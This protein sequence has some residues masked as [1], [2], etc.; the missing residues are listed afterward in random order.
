MQLKNLGNFSIAINDFIKT[1]N[2]ASNTGDILS[3]S[4]Q[5]LTAAEILA[6]AATLN[7]TDSQKLQLI[8]EYATD[9][10]NYTTVESLAALSASEATATTT[11][12]GLSTAFKGLAASIG[13]AKLIL[14]GITVALVAGLAIWNMHQN[15]LENIR[16]STEESANAYKETTSSID[17]YTK[18]YQEL[19]QALIDAKGNEEETYNI[20]KQLLDLQTELND[21][22]G[23]EY[24]KLNLVTDAYKD[25]SEAIKTFNKEAAQTFL[26][27]NQEGI[28]DAT[29]AMTKDN[30]RYNLSGVGMSPYTDEGMALKEIAKKYEN[31]GLKI[32][33][34]ESN[35]TYNLILT[36]DAQSAY[37]TINE[38]ENDVRAKAK[39]LGDEH[40]FDD[41]LEISSS[42]L[43]RAK[44]IINDYGNIYK[45]ALMAEIVTDDDRSSTYN[46]ALKAV[47]EYNE[48]V[49]KS[50]NPFN[51]EEVA[52]TKA[53]I[54]CEIHRVNKQQGQ[55]AG[56]A[57]NDCIM[58]MYHYSPIMVT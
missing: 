32:N 19:R 23:E 13:T 18:R 21:K 2:L 50:E 54:E 57:Y 31:Q 17:D 11:T 46:E 26:N 20:K 3:K 41:V 51:D 24:G 5:K 44:E 7:L 43:N 52:R 4:F 12:G 10:A 38:F 6:K 29:K 9:A 8:T 16:Q 48:A 30:R 40:I 55:Y 1:G 53:N 25:H 56:T 33:E 36:T 58:A 37:D 27:E 34:D 47:E 14:G 42:E 22:F 15:H 39:E 49:L 28:E 45:Q 35:G